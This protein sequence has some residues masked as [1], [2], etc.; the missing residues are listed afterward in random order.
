MANNR[1]TKVIE[2]FVTLADS[3]RMAKDLIVLNQDGVQGDK[4]YNKNVQRSVLLTSLDAYMLAKKNGIKIEY[5]KLGE[6]ILVDCSINLLLPG[7]QFYIGDVLLEIT[8]NCTICKGLTSVDTQ[9][10]FLLKDN[11]GI[12]AKTVTNGTIKKGDTLRIL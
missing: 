9:L 12:F 3:T 10:P 7:Q 2:L 4:F 11:R 8:Q 1:S 5:G 6:N